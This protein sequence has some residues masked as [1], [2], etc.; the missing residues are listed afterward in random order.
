MHKLQ[1]A[2]IYNGDISIKSAV[3]T[4]TCT[5]TL[6]LE[7]EMY[8]KF[9]V[10]LNEKKGKIRQLLEE[11][12]HQSTPPSVEA[13]GPDLDTKQCRPQTDQPNDVPSHHTAA[14]PHSLSAGHTM[15]EK[16]DCSIVHQIIIRSVG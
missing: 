6:Q 8:S 5:T 1:R 13:T 15:Y 9:K 3:R 11:A 2:G 16:H 7:R 10:V 12:S 4:Y 14:S